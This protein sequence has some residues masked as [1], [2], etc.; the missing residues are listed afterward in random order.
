MDQYL[1]WLNTIEMI[2]FIESKI[3]TQQQQQQQ[4]NNNNNNNNNIK[5]FLL[6]NSSSSS[7]SSSSSYQ[8]IYLKWIYLKWI[9]K[10]NRINRISFDKGHS[11]NIL[12]DTSPT[13]TT[14]L[15]IDCTLQKYGR[16]YS[17]N[18]SYSLACYSSIIPI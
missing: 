5:Q 10:S 8:W 3:S 2:D 18:P 13:S 1:E 9:L 12:K 15:S 6:P 14:T 7:S 11:Y 16:V 17:T 4:D